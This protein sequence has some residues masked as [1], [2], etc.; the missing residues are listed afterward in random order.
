VEPDG[1][2][3]VAPEVLGRTIEGESDS[4]ADLQHRGG[5]PFILM[6]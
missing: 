4:K 3:I 6:K 2:G 5:D 1:A